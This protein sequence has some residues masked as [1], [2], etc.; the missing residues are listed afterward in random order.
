VTEKLTPR[1]ARGL[2][3]IKLEMGVFADVKA[4]EGRDGRKEAD[5]IRA[6]LAWIESH[7]TSTHGVAGTQGGQDGAR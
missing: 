2:R 7:L 6:A 4:T 5:D 1:V 3:K